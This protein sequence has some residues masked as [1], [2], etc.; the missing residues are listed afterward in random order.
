[1]LLVDCLGRL[2]D[3]FRAVSPLT[4]RLELETPLS[5][6]LGLSQPHDDEGQIP[7]GHQAVHVLHALPPRSLLTSGR[8]HD[9]VGVCSHDLWDEGGGR[10]IHSRYV[11]V[12]EGADEVVHLLF[13]LGSILVRRQG[14]DIQPRLNLVQATTEGLNTGV[15]ARAIAK[16]AEGLVQGLRSSTAPRIVSA[17]PPKIIQRNELVLHASTDDPELRTLLRLG[18]KL[19]HCKVLL[20]Y[21]GETPDA[22]TIR[23][24]MTLIS[25]P[26]RWRKMV[27]S[28]RQMKRSEEMSPY[29]FIGT[30]LHPLERRSS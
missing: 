16:D 15:M 20:R 27:S 5:I 3:A 11:A 19:T 25:S 23:N 21:A 14:H 13:V 29:D 30:G 1:M 6:P 26:A 10:A 7:V 22:S 18:R 17:Y 24:G 8:N 2:A 12:E 9:S 28:A 4:E